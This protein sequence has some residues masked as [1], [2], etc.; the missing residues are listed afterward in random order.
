MT[1]TRSGPFLAIL[2]AALAP[3]LGCER[4]PQ[5]RWSSDFASERAALRSTGRNPYFVLEPGYQLVLEDGAQRLTVTV[6]DETRVVDGVE[7]RVVEERET[8]DDAPVEVSRNFYAISGVTNSVYYFGEDVDTYR[9][10]QLSGHGGAWLAGVDDA[11]FG[12]MMPGLPLLGA[13]YYQEWAPGVA[14]DRARVIG[15][16]DTLT[17]PAGVFDGV[18]VTEET[19]PLEPGAERKY[20][21]RGVGLL[22]DG[23]L[24]LVRYGFTTGG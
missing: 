20:Y 1:L 13:A 24:R 8:N 12:L 22:R 10:G 21:A 16:S 7:T 11:R 2:I 14:M 18:L 4:A 3:A 5:Q 17:T 19:T 23:S 15:T 9:D 6:L